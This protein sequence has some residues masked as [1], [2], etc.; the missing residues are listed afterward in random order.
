MG[1]GNSLPLFFGPALRITAKEPR[2]ITVPEQKH[3]KPGTRNRNYQV[4]S[5]QT[6]LILL[7]VWRFRHEKGEIHEINYY[8]NF[9][10]KQ[11]H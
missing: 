7:L 6:S 1:Q 9:S 10:R 2:T 8:C 5:C 4:Q 11:C 3:T